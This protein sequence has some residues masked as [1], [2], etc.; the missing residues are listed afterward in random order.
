MG[1]KKTKLLMH[2]SVF[3]VNIN[4]DIENHVKNCSMCLEF[5]QTQP[6]EKNIHYDILLRPWE[7]LGADV[8]QH[9]N[10]NYLCVVDY[11]IATVKI[12]FAEYGIPHTLMSDAG[13][14]FIPERFKRFCNSLNIEEAV[15][16]SYHHQRN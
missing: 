6:K 15:S 14:N 10:K 11:L 9:N 12:I 5:Q 8:F 1:I 3:W 7:V 16:S 13:S 2:E 4:N